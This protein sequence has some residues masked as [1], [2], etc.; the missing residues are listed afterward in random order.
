M[1][2][3]IV[4]GV[5]KTINWCY[6]FHFQANLS[7]QEVS[8][9]EFVRVVMTSVC[10]STVDVRKW[11]SKKKGNSDQNPAAAFRTEVRVFV[12]PGGVHQLNGGKI[13]QRSEILK[14]FLNSGQKQREA[15]KALQSL[16]E[17]AELPNGQSLSS[18]RPLAHGVGGGGMNE[19]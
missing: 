18:L 2:H 6:C 10:L 8:S 19:F 1:S 4:A 11:T 9:T 15:L 13:I 5:Y 7:N 16:K 14:K 17:H 3:A 12:V